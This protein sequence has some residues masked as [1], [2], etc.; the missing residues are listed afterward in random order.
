MIISA[1]IWMTKVQRPYFLLR[2]LEEFISNVKVTYFYCNVVSN[3]ALYVASLILDDRSWSSSNPLAHWIHLLFSVTSSTK[4]KNTTLSSWLAIIICFCKPHF[5][6]Q[7]FRHFIT[8]TTDILFPRVFR[9]LTKPFLHQT[10]IFKYLTLSKGCYK[11]H[12]LPS[13]VLITPL[14]STR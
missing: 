10:H 3:E 4:S 2:S 12:I 11:R 7:H 9:I 8:F 13:L 14:S 6:S 1:S 5:C